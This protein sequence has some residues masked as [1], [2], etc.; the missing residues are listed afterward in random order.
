MRMVCSEVRQWMGNT[1]LTWFLRCVNHQKRGTGKNFNVKF[2]CNKIALPCTH[3]KLPCMLWAIV[4]SIGYDI[5]HIFRTWLQTIIYFFQNYIRECGARD[6]TTTVNWLGCG[7]IMQGV[8]L[9]PYTLRVYM[10]CRG[11]GSGVPIK[12]R[13]YWTRYVDDTPT[14]EVTPVTMRYIHSPHLGYP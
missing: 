8:G 6:M 10:Y 13:L 4:G 1:M 11:R 14:S 12:R 3:A 2:S 9:N 7:G 5:H